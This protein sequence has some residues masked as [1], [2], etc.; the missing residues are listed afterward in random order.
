MT[1]LS[2]CPSHERFVEIAE[3]HLTVFAS[4]CEAADQVHDM[5]NC[6]KVCVC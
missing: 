3:C 4:C 2:V 6:Y 1:V 5:F